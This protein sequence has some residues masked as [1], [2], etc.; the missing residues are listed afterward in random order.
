[1]NGTTHINEEDTGYEQMPFKLIAQLTDLLF[2]EWARDQRMC[3]SADLQHRFDILKEVNLSRERY[4]LL[5]DE[6]DYEPSPADF[7]REAVGL[8][9]VVLHLVKQHERL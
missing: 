7:L 3:T 8:H 2:N 6:N 1:M 5:L 9:K 4:L